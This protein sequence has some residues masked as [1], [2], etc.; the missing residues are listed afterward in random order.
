MH[1]LQDST[2]VRCTQFCSP[3][4]PN[5]SSFLD[6]LLKYLTPIET[7]QTFIQFLSSLSKNRNDSILSSILF[8]HLYVGTH[9]VS[10]YRVSSCFLTGSCIY[11]CMCGATPCLWC[12]YPCSCTVKS[13]LTFCCYKSCNEYPCMYIHNVAHVQ[14]C[15]YP[16]FPRP[17]SM[18]PNLDF[19]QSDSV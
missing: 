2:C 14:I 9:S 6:V 19:L 4:A 17:H 18:F 11:L 1:D 3:G 16:C 12:D 10:F 5:I 8:F 15:K 13:L 7:Y